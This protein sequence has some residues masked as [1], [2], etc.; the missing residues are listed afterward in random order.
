MGFKTKTE[1][2][3]YG[4]KWCPVGKNW[5]VQTNWVYDEWEVY[6]QAGPIIVYTDPSRFPDKFH[7]RLSD[8]CL[9][10]S[11][12]YDHGQDFCNSVEEAAI[13]EITAFLKYDKAKRAQLDQIQLEIARTGIKT[14]PHQ[15]EKTGQCQEQ[16]TT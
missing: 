9:I 10:E 7:A 11:K 2:F 13:E 3:E 16:K 15:L 5:A 6:W 4:K 12:L 8:R 1:A 14:H